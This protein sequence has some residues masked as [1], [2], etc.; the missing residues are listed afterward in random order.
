MLVCGGRDGVMEAACEGA[1]E[2]GGTTVGLLPGNSRAEANRFVD[3]AIPTGMGEM[4]NA[5]IVRTADALVA[6]GGKWGTLSEVA[7]ALQAGKPV[8]AVESFELEG[9]VVCADG[10][11]AAQR[12]IDTTLR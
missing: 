12:A 6:I 5:L 4:R 11:E 2:A 8:F 3:I 7:L 9:L 1:R 10:A